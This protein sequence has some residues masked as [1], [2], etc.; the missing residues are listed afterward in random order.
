MDRL[1]ERRATILSIVVGEYIASGTPVASESMARCYSLKVSPATI[2]NDMASLEEEGYIRRP[3]TSAG[4][5]PSD[6]GYR[7]YVECL[8]KEA[9]ISRKDR[10]SIQEF[11][12]QAEQEPDEWARLAVSV[13]TQRLRS[14][15]L[16]TPPRASGCHF[17][18]LDLIALQDLLIMLVL[19][20]QE[21]GIKQRLIAVEEVISQDGLTAVANKM[22]EVYQGLDYAEIRVGA[23]DLYL[24]LLE[25]S[26]TG[27]IVHMMEA[28]NK[29][30]HGQ[31][32]IDGW[33]Y[34]L[35]QGEITRSRRLLDLVEALE[36]RSILS[37]LIGNLDHGSGI[38]I[39]IGNEN[40]NEALRE[41]SVILSNYG[42]C[43]RTGTIG[44]IGPTR[45]SYS[46][47]IPMINYLSNLMSDLIVEVYS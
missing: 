27:V 36:E 33:R 11:F 24:S 29:R 42:A 16:A 44:I 43:G 17:R 18:R 1:L 9:E 20:L 10:R 21:G 40:E 5:I 12:Y 37:T 39:I 25:E 41:C 31:F 14:I 23:T 6:R 26:I 4:A 30:R 19:V 35:G 2:R 32:Y 22:N 38:K 7:Y 47:A 28:E 13:L 8:M 45:M 3:H 15:A 34:L 46:R